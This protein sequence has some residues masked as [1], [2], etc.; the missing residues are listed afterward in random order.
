[1]SQTP[2]ERLFEHSNPFQTGKFGPSIEDIGCIP[3]TN[4]LLADL[5]NA[6]QS[7]DTTDRDVALFFCEALL[8]KHP[9][10]AELIAAVAPIIYKFICSDDKFL[11]YS[12][13][14]AFIH[15]KDR[16]KDYRERMLQFLTNSESAACTR[17]LEAS[18]TFLYPNEIQP[19]IAFQNDTEVSETEKMGG[20][21][22]YMRRDMALGKIER[23]IGQSFAKYESSESKE[24]KVIFWWDWAPFL[25]WWNKQHGKWRSWLPF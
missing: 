21:W 17:A 11:P 1:M 10:S 15:L 22:R 12:A 7:N 9:Q 3:I 18:E 16:F 13:V 4:I 24:D 5:A 25:E 19:L 8:V 23:M 20:P 14:P 2:H 6:L